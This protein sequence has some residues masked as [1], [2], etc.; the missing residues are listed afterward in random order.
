M[1]GRT[2]LVTGWVVVAFAAVSALPVTR[3]VYNPQA[4]DIDHG[5]VVL[6]RTFPFDWTPLP[7]PRISYIE[8]VRPLTQS[9]NGGHPCEDRGGPFR[10]TRSD[11]VGIWDI[12]SWA[13]PC[14]DDPRGYVW[15]AHW[16]WHLG[17]IK[18]GPVELSEIVLR[19]EG[20]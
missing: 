7:R 8:V 1:M 10:Y 17:L 16:S 3:L 5:T 14:L 15:T 6:Q 19:I 4:V 13:E 11:P 20:S 2:A 18:F 12:G 9:H